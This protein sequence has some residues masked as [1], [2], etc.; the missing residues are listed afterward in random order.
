MSKKAVLDRMEVI[1]AEYT[2][3]KGMTNLSPKAISKAAS[4]TSAMMKLEDIK[5]G[6][7]ANQKWADENLMKFEVD[8]SL[9]GLLT[10]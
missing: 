3:D 10:R 5:E 1:V 2:D 8:Q 7:I 6:I 4:W 9:I